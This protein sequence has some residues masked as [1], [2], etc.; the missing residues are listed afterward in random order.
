MLSG[1]FKAESVAPVAEVDRLFVHVVAVHAIEL[2][3]V[4][5]RNVRIGRFDVFGLFNQGLDV[6]T[7]LAVVNGR[8]LRVG[9]VGTVAD[10][11]FHAFGNV[12][13]GSGGR[14]AARSDGAQQN[15]AQSDEF[16]K[17]YK[18]CL[19]GGNQNKTRRNGLSKSFRRNQSEVTLRY[20]A[21][22][23]AQR[24]VQI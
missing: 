19:C 14:V 18:Q 9:L 20:V 17:T 16:G 12:P 15:C 22:P 10:L 1:Y 2:I 23:S 11:T 8:Q 5:R 4:V 24:F 3:L 13:F 21:R 6:M 7:G